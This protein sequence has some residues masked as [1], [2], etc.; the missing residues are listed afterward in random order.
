MKRLERILLRLIVLPGWLVTVIAV[1]SFALVIYVQANHLTDS[2]LAYVGYAAS[3]YALTIVAV[4]VPHMVASLHTGFERHPLVQRMRYSQRGQRF[5]SEPMYRAEVALY[6][7]LLVNLAYA[8]IKMVSGVVFHSVWFGALAGYYLLL[9]AIR[10]AL[11]HHTRR[12]PTGQNLLS[13]WKRYRL[14]GVILLVMNQALSV[15]VILV[16]Q[17]NSGAEYPGYLI[18]IMAMYTFYAVINAVRNVVK[19][20]SQGSPVL[21]AAKSASLIAALVS[22]LSLETAM[23]SQFGGEDETHYRQIMT[24]CTG[25]VVCMTVLAMAVYMIVHST[26]QI[27]SMKQGELTR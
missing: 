20:R 21:S 26:R 5:L 14:C 10:F 17:R 23:L 3:A 12:N 16:V 9:S 11:L 15:V 27:R 1:P 19:S 8:A 2:P 18:Y 24:G 13:E 6:A 25:F 4:N 7:G 22:M